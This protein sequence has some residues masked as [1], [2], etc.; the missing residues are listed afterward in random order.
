MI[1]DNYKFNI[2]N[3]FFKLRT[4][5]YHK[6]KLKT[7][8]EPILQIYRIYVLHTKCNVNDCDIDYSFLDNESNYLIVNIMLSDK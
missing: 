3:N 2:N 6:T 4:T 8:K 5:D 7:S 1:I